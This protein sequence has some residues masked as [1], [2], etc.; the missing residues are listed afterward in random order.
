MLID[1]LDP[2]TLDCIVEPSFHSS[3]DKAAFSSLM[4][5]DDYWWDRR[6]RELREDRFHYSD[7]N[8]SMLCIK[9]FR[10]GCVEEIIVFLNA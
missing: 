10:W 7:D 3:Q 5:Q 4:F 9:G 8:N 1:Y 6:K 2:K